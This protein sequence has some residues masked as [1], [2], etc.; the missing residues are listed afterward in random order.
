MELKLMEGEDV[1]R[2]QYQHCHVGSEKVVEADPKQRSVC[3]CKAVRVAAAIRFFIGNGDVVHVN[4]GAWHHVKEIRQ[5]ALL[6]RQNVV[7]VEHHFEA[8]DEVKVHCIKQARFVG[9]Q[10]HGVLKATTT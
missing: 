4:H 1:V 6:I 5:Q 7:E 2:S 3:A 8:R 9:S 10:R